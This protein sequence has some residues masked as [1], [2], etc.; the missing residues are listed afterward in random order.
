ML[1][2][3]KLDF[4]DCYT[5]VPVYQILTVKNVTEDTMEVFFDS[6]A[7]HE[8][9]FD[10]I[11][12]NDQQEN[13]R[14]RTAADEAYDSDSNSSSDSEADTADTNG[15]RSLAPCPSAP[16]QFLLAGLCAC[17]G[18]IFYS[19]PIGYLIDR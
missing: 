1:S 9:S 14:Q 17:C 12:E 5:S 6:D 13:E 18:R 8:V 19:P 2:V 3:A 11:T 4:G 7:S 10:L 16:A 15:T